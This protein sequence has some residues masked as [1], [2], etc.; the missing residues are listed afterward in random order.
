[1]GETKIVKLYRRLDKGNDE[2][3]ALIHECLI[4]AM[5]RVFQEIHFA[6][7]QDG[8]LGEE[9]AELTIHSNRRDSIQ[10]Y[11][12]V[13]DNTSG[14]STCLSVILL[15]SGDPPAKIVELLDSLEFVSS[16]SSFKDRPRAFHS[17]AGYL[18]EPYVVPRL[19]P[20]AGK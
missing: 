6:G 5:P 10:L 3:V 12:V 11:V 15:L 4:R 9:M 7:G 14:Y 8:D 18:D 20:F 19:G 17:F 13:D 1:M 2:T 16:H